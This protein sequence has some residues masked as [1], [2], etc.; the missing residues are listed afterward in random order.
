MRQSMEEFIKKCVVCQQIKYSTESLGG[1][2]QPLPPP[3][4]VR[5]DVSMDFITGL[6]TSRG[7]T[8]IFVVVDRLTKYAHFGALPTSF[9]AHKVVELFVDIVVKHHGIPK[10]IVS[11]RD[12]IFT[13]GQTEVVNRCLEQYLRAMP[14]SVIP[15]PP[16]SSKV[17]VVDGLLVE[18]DGLLRQLKES[19][20]TAKHRIEVKANRKRRDVEFSVGDLVLVKLQPYRQV[21]LAKRLS[22]KLAK[23]YYRPY[24]VEARMGKVAYRLVL[25]AS[26]GSPE[27][28]TWEWLS[29]FKAA[30]PTYNLEDK[31]VF[32]DGGNDTS[33]D[34]QRMR[35]SKRV[36]AAPAW[37]KDF[38]MG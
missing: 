5:E 36:S 23:H 37:Q 32:E 10:T 8:V 25:P 14:L 21:T 28:A 33:P 15:Y 6:P 13:D 1:Y 38:V 12:L 27:E 22:N 19:L 18:R 3:T 11:D 34:G 35:K 24:K 2:L 9:N 4:T 17:S 26:R 20:L 30:Y 7:S 29:E 16:G 31:V